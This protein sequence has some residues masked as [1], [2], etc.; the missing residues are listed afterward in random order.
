MKFRKICGFKPLTQ[1]DMAMDFN[2]RDSPLPTPLPSNNLESR[3]EDKFTQGRF[4]FGGVCSFPPAPASTVPTTPL[5]QL[6]EDSL[7]LNTLINAE[8]E[9]GTFRTKVEAILREWISICYTTA[10]QIEPQHAFA[11]ISRMVH[12]CK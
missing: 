3:N 12:F 10:A 4:H 6:L 11:S 2:H 5:P 8:D 7:R 1:Q 9:E